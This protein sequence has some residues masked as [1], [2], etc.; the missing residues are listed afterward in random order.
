MPRTRLLMTELNELIM[1]ILVFLLMFM[2][3]LLTLSGVGKAVLTLPSRF[4]CEV[5]RVMEM[6]YGELLACVTA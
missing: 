2:T 4:G 6:V 5:I 3:L 1:S